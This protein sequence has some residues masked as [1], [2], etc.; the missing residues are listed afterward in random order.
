MVHRSRAADVL[1]ALGGED[2]RSHIATLR[3]Q[4]DANAIR[5]AFEIVDEV[6]V[7]ITD[8]ETLVTLSIRQ[9]QIDSN[10]VGLFI[11]LQRAMPDERLEGFLDELAV[12]LGS[13]ASDERGH[14]EIVDLGYRLAVRRVRLGETDA[15]RLLA[16]LAPLSD[17]YG[18]NRDA[19]GE[20]AGLVAGD[21]QLR[22]A[23]LRITLLEGS[24]DESIRSRAL[25]LFTRNNGFTPKPEDIVQLLGEIDTVGPQDNR[26]RDL[27]EL[28]RHSATEGAEVREA[29]KRH[30]ANRPDMIAWIDRLIEPRVPDWEIRQEEDRRKRRARDEMAW[31]EHRE[32]Y[33]RCA[34][35]IRRGDR[36]PLITLARAYLNH[37]HNLPE[38]E[39]PHER[40]VAWLGEDLAAIASEGFEAFIRSEQGPTATQIAEENANSVALFAALIIVAG[41]AERLRLGL[42]LE[43]VSDDRLTLAFH[44]LRRSRID[45]HAKLP[46]LLPAVEA[47]MDAR[48]LT[49]DAERDWLERQIAHRCSFIDRLHSLMNREEEADF[50]T[51]MAL[52]WLETYPDIPKDPEQD[53]I[54][55]L[56]RSHRLEDLR[57]FGV[58]RIARDIDVDR[59]RNWDAVLLLTDFEAQRDRLT[60][61]AAADTEWLWTI[62]SRLG[63]DRHRAVTA[64]LPPPQ[65]SWLFETFRPLFPAVPHPTGAVRS[66]ETPWE[67]SEYLSGVA[68]RLAEVTTDEAIEALMR[69][70]DAKADGYTIHLRTI[71]AEQRNRRAERLYTPPTLPE[72]RTVVE[73]GPPATVA[74]L[75]ATMVVLLNG[76]QKRIVSDPADPWRG[77]YGDDGVPYDE[78]RCRDHLLTML[79]VRPSSIDLMPE[80]HLAD[81]NRADIICTLS[82]MRLPIEVKGQWHPEVWRAADDQLDRLYTPDYAAERRGIYL[83]LWFGPD[84]PEGKK[85]RAN[86]LGRRRPIDPD[87]VSA[88]LAAMSR[89]VQDG[90]VEV[91]VLDLR[92]P[93]G[94]E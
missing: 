72:V 12:Q 16:W 71:A 62:R 82:G 81:D 27:V 50:A 8:D 40:M 74:D 10:S 79:G 4:D 38:A 37:F 11:K 20:L 6:G 58:E 52:R 87:E 18:Y 64:Q 84:V 85:P 23:G 32:E 35:E 33:R 83:V 24:T 60:Q 43:D 5:L 39:V 93:G 14:S 66:G 47:E 57:R 28:V 25:T 80:G 75:Q 22:L 36:N 61:V 65:L 70:R 9:Q 94:E 51:E 63:G 21:D 29:A 15:R 45:D 34:D 48:S 44:E 53:L 67:A 17:R 78:E 13:I 54:D 1:V 31:R 77:F 49:R 88:E 42:G 3:A 7:A 69:L 89:A 76:V 91:V 2:W 68:A 26:W 55:R 41:L 73:A 46:E 86:G 30:V 92:K 90:R 59:R 56:I 19:R